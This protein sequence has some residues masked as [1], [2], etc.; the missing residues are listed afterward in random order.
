VAQAGLWDVDDT[1]LRPVNDPSLARALLHKVNDYNAKVA[2]QSTIVCFIFASLP[3][4]VVSPASVFATLF[5]G[6]SI[7]S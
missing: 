7:L 4:D 2:L 5:A 3:K 1:G 6:N